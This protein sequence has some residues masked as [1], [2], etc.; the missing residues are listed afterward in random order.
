MPQT[1]LRVLL[2]YPAP[3]PP[4]PAPRPG[5]SPPP[6]QPGGAPTPGRIPEGAW[7]PQPGDRAAFGDSVEGA[8]D[9]WRTAGATVWLDVAGSA[10]DELDH[11]LEHELEFLARV[12]GLHA[13]AI[14]SALRPGTRARV[15]HHDHGIA[16]TLSVPRIGSLSQAGRL[17]HVEKVEVI[18]GD[19][20]LITV[21][22]DRMP[23]L[24]RLVP[25]QRGAALV[26]AKGIGGLVHQL[27]NGILGTYFPVVDHLVD[28]AES[29]DAEAFSGGAAAPRAVRTVSRVRRELFALR[30][31]VAPQR[32]ALMLLARDRS[33]FPAAPEPVS[34]QDVLDQAVRLEQ[35]LSVHHEVLSGARTAYH[36][37]IATTVARASQ[38]L[39]V[40]TCLLVV[41]TLVTS[42]YG[43][44]FAHFPELG[45]PLGHLW[46]LLLILA[47]DGALWR[48]FRRR[49]WV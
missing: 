30:R 19:R 44:N 38:T 32:S 9:A 40:G 25:P 29:R 20:F 43:M 26:A 46:A 36:S 41:P 2:L 3:P 4:A 23:L 17:T 35:A 33:P 13:V 6:G 14:A 24:E 18:F 15:Q 39:L 12:F 34:L 45:W 49:G 11:Q 8:L 5:P 16:L 27:I 42:L 31:V 10:G 37:W 1:M 22:A 48:A 7:A 21:H 28:V 47:I